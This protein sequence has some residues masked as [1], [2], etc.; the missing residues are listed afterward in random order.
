MFPYARVA[1][2]FALVACS[3]S[4]DT[5]A[6]DAGRSEDAQLGEAPG[7][8]LP[9]SSTDCTAPLA[10]GDQRTCTVQIGGSSRTYLLYA[11]TSYDP[12]RPAA[13]VVDAHGAQESAEVH[14]GLAN[15]Y[16]WPTL[17]IGSG[18]RLVADREG[19]LVATPQGIGNAWAQS[20]TTFVTAI[21][22][23]VGVQAAVD[24]D[25]VY[26]SGISNGGG[27]TY[28]TACGDSGVFHGF[29]PISGYDNSACPVTHPA[30]LVQFHSPD[31]ALVSYTS[32]QTSFLHWREANHCD[33]T[34]TETLRFGGANGDPRPVCLSA[35]EPWKLETC[36]T[37]APATVC[38]RY[39]GCDH[40]DAVF[41]T[42]PP[43]NQ[44]DGGQTGGHILY[45]NA[46][47]LSL[48]A[49]TWAI[50]EM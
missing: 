1:T 33:A 46:T 14:A 43:D 10:P 50:L 45:F 13:L 40:G 2:L 29:A 22:A 39:T 44:Y 20:D 25:R 31:D 41:C 7:C 16:S 15:F 21:P 35:G 32:G 12:C 49:V 28:W 30:P 23:A 48:A 5:T 17:G 8:T 37:S 4:Q 47:N 19:F 34:P 3:S 18:F 38:Q 6:P 27:L 9:A 11:P 24:A 26:L 42:V 36:N